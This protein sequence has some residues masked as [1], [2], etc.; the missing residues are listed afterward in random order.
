MILKV[1]LSS[2][3]CGEGWITISEVKLSDSEGRGNQH[4][5][6][7]RCAPINVVQATGSVSGAKNNRLNLTL[8]AYKCSVTQ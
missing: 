1:Q 6:Y 7:L 3:V 2:I 4:G 8:D 5:L